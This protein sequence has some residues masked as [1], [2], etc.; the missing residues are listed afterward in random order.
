MKKTFAPRGFVTASVMD[1]IYRIYNRDSAV[2]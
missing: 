2:C 1:R